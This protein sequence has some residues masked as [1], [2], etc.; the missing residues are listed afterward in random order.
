Q[1]LDIRYVITDLAERNVQFWEGHKRLR[2]FRDAGLLDCAVYSPEIEDSVVIRHAGI[3]LHPGEIRNPI[4]VI[5]NCFFERVRQDL[6]RISD[7]R[8]EEVL[9]STYRDAQPAPT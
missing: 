6:F 9:V 7:G 1:G 5:A 2:P 3:T 4:I 8:L